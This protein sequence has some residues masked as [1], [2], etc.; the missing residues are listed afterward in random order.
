M[1]TLF[2]PADLAEKFDT[3][4]RTVRKFLRSVTPKE[5]QPGKG[6]RWAIEGKKLSSLRSQYVKWVA[7]Q[8]EKRAQREAEVAAETETDETTPED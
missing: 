8:D 4:A 2:T 6:S 1:A 3:D 7:A 5:D